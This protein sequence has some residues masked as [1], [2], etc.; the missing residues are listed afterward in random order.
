MLYH[1]FDLHHAM[2]TP[3]R[4]TAELMRTAYQHPMN[5]LSYTQGGRSLAASAE[6]FERVTRRFGKPS[7]ELPTTFIDGKTVEVE[8][9]TVVE[10]PFAN[11]VHFRR[12][13]DR[14]DPKVLIVA[15]MSG[16]YATLLRGTVE[17]LLPHHDVY[18][19]DWHDARQVPL[20]EGRF[21]LDDYIAYVR[22]FLSLLGT[23]VHV[24]AVCQ[25]AVPVFAA[26]SLMESDDDPALPLTMTLMGG[27][28]DA[29]V[30]PTKVNEMAE[31]NPGHWLA[32]TVVTEVPFYYPGAFRKVYPGFVQLGSFVSM[33][34]DRHIGSHMKFFHHLVEGDG[35]SAETHRKFY[36]EYLSVMDIPGEFYLQTVDVVF[37]R[38]LLPQGKM[39]WKNPLNEQTFSVNPGAIKRT[40][41]LTVEGELDDISANGQTTAAHDLATSLPAERQ[42]HHFQEKTGHYGIFNGRKWREEIMPRIRHLI[43]Q[44]DPGA[45]PVP[46]ADLTAIPDKAPAQWDRSEHGIDAVKARKAKAGKTAKEFEVAE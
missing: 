16:H 28:I 2:L 4:M 31:R 32:K 40:V 12:K 45:D 42:Y 9:Q 35:D 8:E 46:T 37:Q 21:N 15:P 3:I 43:R 44:F 19:T 10:M 13:I 17:A 24:V 26:V 5:P 39:V 27:P 18:I 14:H 20:S 11:L 7:F 23:G 41:L 36:D 25:P 6:I 34:L 29:R 30:S 33:N 1:F 22:E 38:F